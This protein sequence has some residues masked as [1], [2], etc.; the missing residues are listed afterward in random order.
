M[1][2][3]YRRNTDDFFGSLAAIRWPLCLVFGAGVAILFW[4]PLP[5][6]GEIG[7]LGILLWGE[8]VTGVGVALSVNSG[9]K[10][11]GTEII[12]VTSIAEVI[13][14]AL[15]QFR[16]LSSVTARCL[17]C[18]EK[19]SA[20]RVYSRANGRQSLQLLCQCGACNSI[21]PLYSERT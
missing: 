1:I 15:E 16:S 11:L 8:I 18:K 17:S 9:L 3:T 21:H 2:N 12:H 6:T 10:Q 7:F 5:S 19:L 14:V 13:Q 4:S 20:D